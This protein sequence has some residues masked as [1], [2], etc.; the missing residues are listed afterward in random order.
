M[1]PIAPPPLIAAGTT[2]AA[3]PALHIAPPP[4]DETARRIAA[5]EDRMERLERRLADIER[6]ANVIVPG[7]V[8]P[9]PAA[10]LAP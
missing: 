8:Q 7:P 6:R 4:S 10:M 3:E 1:A 9:V 2:P 5:L